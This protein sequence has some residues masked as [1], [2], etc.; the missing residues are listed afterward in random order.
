MQRKYINEKEECTL[1]SLSNAA[2]FSFI[3]RKQRQINNVSLTT[4]AVFKVA[5]LMFKKS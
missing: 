1:S 3:K 5:T 4:F 2:G